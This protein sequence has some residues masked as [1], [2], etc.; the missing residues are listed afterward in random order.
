[1][2]RF[3]RTAFAAFF[4]DTTFRQPLSEQAARK[5][6]SQVCRVPTRLATESKPWRSR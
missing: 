2:I 4:L 1:M 6:Q 5:E 3:G